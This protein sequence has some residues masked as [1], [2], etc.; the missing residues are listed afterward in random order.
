MLRGVR[1][2]K[3]R[4]AEGFG[5]FGGFGASCAAWS[6]GLDQKMT[7]S[8]TVCLSM[9]CLVA[10]I[11]LLS[12]GGD[13]DLRALRV[14]PHAHGPF[15]WHA[16]S[17][18]DHLARTLPAVL[19]KGE[20]GSQEYSAPRAVLRI[21]GAGDESELDIDQGLDS[22]WEQWTAMIRKAEQ[23]FEVLNWQV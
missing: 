21:S 19:L 1:G 23:G 9:V 4:W 17:L 5:G 18:P 14:G 16:P 15:L 7:R 11:Q 22:F 10:H 8:S 20:R 3:E 6:S 12:A 2:Q 13:E